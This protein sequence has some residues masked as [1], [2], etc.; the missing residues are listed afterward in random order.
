M[1][2]GQPL[3]LEDAIADPRFSS[4]VYLKSRRPRSTICLPL[5]KNGATSGAIYIENRRLVGSFTHNRVQ[6]LTLLSHQVRALVENTDLSQQLSDNVSSLEGALRNIALLERMKEHL[7]KFVP[8]TVQRLINQNPEN[9]DL[10]TRSAD[11]SVMFLDMSGYTALSE[12]F[13]SAELN[14]I[15]E[16]YFSNFFDDIHNAGGDISEVAGDGLMIIFQNECPN[17]HAASAVR[18][19]IAV[20]DKT[21]QLN[22]ALS[23]KWPTIKINIGIHSGNVL[24]GA[25]KMQSAGGQGRWTFTV[26]GFAANLA[27]R[28]CSFAFDG[29]VVISG[30]TASRVVDHFELNKLGDKQ[31][32][33]VSRPIE[34]FEVRRARMAIGCAET[35]VMSGEA[36]GSS[37][38]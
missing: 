31:F 15:V 30:E 19:A 27:A 28:I 23:G 32:K 12:Q 26:T 18:A 22:N 36:T 4:C 13:D 9:P 24:I 3:I 34:I 21:V 33:G 35:A 17:R 38:A 37:E 20:R 16:T 2:T 8:L 1:R 7:E 6:A 25:H 11:V 29:A 10:Q 14:A 5:T